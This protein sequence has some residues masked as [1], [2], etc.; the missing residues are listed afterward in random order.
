MCE[1]G[2][3][4]TN[5]NMELMIRCFLYMFGLTIISILIAFCNVNFDTELKEEEIIKPVVVE[6]YSDS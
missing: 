2:L 3:K 1:I 4:V 6:E 5:G